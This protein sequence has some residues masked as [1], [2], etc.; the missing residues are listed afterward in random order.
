MAS[1]RHPRTGSDPARLAAFRDLVASISSSLI[2]ADFDR[3]DA[4]IQ[5][6]LA[7]LGTFTGVDRSYVFLMHEDD[8]TRCDNTHEWC[9][10]G[11][12]PQFDNLQDIDLSSYREIH[13]VLASGEVWACPSVADLPP[14]LAAVF[15]EQDIQSLV[16]VPMLLKQRLIGF[17]GFDWVRRREE[18]FDE[19]VTLLRIVGEII[20]QA[21]DR[22]R[23]ER[24]LFDYQR[25]LRELTSALRRRE[26]EARREAA[27][28]LHDGIGQELAALKLQL[29]MLARE[30][31]EET[32]ARLADLLPP[33]DRCSE[34]VRSMTFQLYPPSLQRSG[35]V[36]ALADLARHYRERGL[37]EIE[38]VC[39]SGDPDFSQ[40]VREELFLAVRELLHNV[41]KHAGCHE[42]TVRLETFDD[43]IELSVS[44]R[45]RGFDATD[46]QQET[47]HRY[48]YGLFNLEE[49]LQEMGGRI[50]VDSAP[51]RGTTVTL[52]CP[53]RHR[54]GHDR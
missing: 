39:P 30:L 27:R 20:A 3:I 21:V 13:D 5:E 11:I 38:L 29:Q 18:R 16:L 51:G 50:S 22:Y 44:D 41:R 46:W 9:A 6:A 17:I 10:E 53:C 23:S 25:R 42:A 8:P 52:V 43:R 54:E 12:E 19:L 1:P 40:R 28:S 34:A 2:A 37:L 15:Q 48:G 33:L 24:R 45:G 47:G 4:T 49:R 14:D 31:D 26:R 35:L 36:A 32:G 7:R